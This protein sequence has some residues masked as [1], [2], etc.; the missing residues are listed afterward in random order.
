MGRRMRI[1]HESLLRLISSN[2]DDTS[3][4][5]AR[6]FH[7]SGWALRPRRPEDQSASSPANWKLVWH[8]DD[9]SADHRAAV[10][11]AA[12]EFAEIYDVIW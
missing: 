1:T 6:Y 5:G 3:A 7:T 8:E 11:S 10:E 9:A 12:A 2:A 4:P